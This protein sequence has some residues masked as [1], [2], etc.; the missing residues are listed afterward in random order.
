MNPHNFERLSILQGERSVKED[1]QN[2]CGI[3]R[4]RTRS[5]KC[6]YVLQ[7]GNK[8]EVMPPCKEKPVFSTPLPELSTLSDIM[9]KQVPLSGLEASMKDAVMIITLLVDELKLNKMDGAIR[10]MAERFLQSGNLRETVLLINSKLH[11]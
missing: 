5:K 1:C 7:D 11:K 8:V 4:I 2:G 3:T 10:Q 9:E 6:F